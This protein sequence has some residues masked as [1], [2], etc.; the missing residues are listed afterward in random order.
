M[1]FQKCHPITL[2]HITSAAWKPNFMKKFHKLEKLWPFL[3]LYLYARISAVSRENPV[4]KQFMKKIGNNAKKMQH[5]CFELMTLHGIKATFTHSGP[6]LSQ[7]GPICRKIGHFGNVLVWNLQMAITPLVFGIFSYNLV[8][9]EHL[10]CFPRFWAKKFWKV[11]FEY[12]SGSPKLKIKG[13]HIQMH[14]SQ[15]GPENFFS[16]FRI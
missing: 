10:W 11:Y 4:F 12:V 15:K 1:I 5:N 6:F 3:C 9:L 14:F 2:E 16:Y 8:S 13:R 7:G